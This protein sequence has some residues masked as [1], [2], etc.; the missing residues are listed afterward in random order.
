MP[1]VVP[2][3]ADV[4]NF[5]GEVATLARPGGHTTGFTMLAPEASGKGLELLNS[6]LPALSRVAVLHHAGAD[7]STYWT[8][9]RKS[10]RALQV[11]APSI[12]HRYRTR[13]RRR[14]FEPW[15]VTRW[16]P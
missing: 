3:C 11:N 1:V 16:E 4:L 15:P 5:M 13:N 14:F 12:S 2:A 10:A 8:D 7:W 6:L 9:M